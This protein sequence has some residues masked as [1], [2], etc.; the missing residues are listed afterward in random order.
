MVIC[1][2]YDNSIGAGSLENRKSITGSTIT[3]KVLG[4]QNVLEAEL[5]QTRGE[6][7]QFVVNN[8]GSVMKKVGGIRIVSE[9]ISNIA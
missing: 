5:S 2:L 4:V 6:M 3:E 8:T 7:Q 9:L 1:F